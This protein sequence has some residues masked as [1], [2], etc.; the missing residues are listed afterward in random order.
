M[1]EA[2]TKPFSGI[3]YNKEKI[4]DISRVVCP[5]YDVISNTA[6]YYE[7]SNQNAIRLELPVASGSM[8]Q[9]TNAKHI[10]DEWLEKEI[11]LPDRKE[12]IYIYEQ[13]FEIEHVSFLRRGFIAL[14]KLDKQRIL[15]HEETRKKAKADR[16]QLIGT[17]KTFTS[18][19]F[20]LYEERK[21]YTTS[22]MS[23][24]S[25]TAFTE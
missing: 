22:S 8:D 21:K 17:L 25:A 13:E 6:S 2:F 1:S 20:G 24:Q 15:T 4:A 18:L 14:H 9:Y 7:R 19:I 10:M 5:P 11:L 16:E 23:S 3:L 12:T